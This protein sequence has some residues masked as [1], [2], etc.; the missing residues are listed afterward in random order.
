MTT[1]Y[2]FGDGSVAYLGEFPEIVPA[3]LFPLTFTDPPYGGIV[4]ESWDKI[5]PNV[6]YQNLIG[7][8]RQ[9]SLLTEPGG[10]IY[11]W[12]GI[13]TPHNRPFYKFLANLEED[14]D[15]TLANHITWVKKRA[16]GLSHN[17]LFVREELAYLSKG[18]PKKPRKFNVPLLSTKRGYAGYNAKYPAKSEYYRR[19]NVWSDIVEI[20]RGKRHPTEKP[21]ALA[22][23]AIQAHTEPGEYVFDPFAGS[24]STALAARELDRRFVLIERDKNTFEQ[25][26]ERLK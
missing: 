11:I 6:H 7:W 10:A 16:Y 5:Q 17:Y 4:N 8:S 25:M 14:T 24:G 1:G 2:Q 20:L 22:K 9:I 21:T 15:L 19:T 18:D 3:R 23:I 12:G 13:G 26:V